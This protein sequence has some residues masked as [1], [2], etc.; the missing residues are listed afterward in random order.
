MVSPPRFQVVPAGAVDSLGARA[1]ELAGNAGLV[2]TEEQ[3]LVL[4]G[5][6]GVR[7]DGGWTA[8]EVANVQPRHNGKSATLM[9]RLMLALD[10]GEQAA[11]TSHR[12]D[13]S[14]EVFRGLVSL[15]EASPDLSPYLQRVIYSNGKES[16]WLAPTAPLELRR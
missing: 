8:F 6:L 1:V 2:L 12:V 14:Q 11:Y 3:R 16:I 10:R 4:H 13:S 5:G 7:A 9:A 15:V